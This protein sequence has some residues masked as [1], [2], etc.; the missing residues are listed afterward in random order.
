M[1][2]IETELNNWVKIFQFN[3]YFL[4]PFVF[5]GQSNSVWSLETSI[6]RTLVNQSKLGFGLMFGYE[7]EEKWMLHEFK[8][9][10]PL[11]SKVLPKQ[12]DNFEWLAIMQ[13]YGAPT[14]LLDFTESLFIATYFSVIESTT[15]SA[16][17]CVN[18]YQLRDSLHSIF[19]LNY[20][21]GVQLK[22]EINDIHIELA[23]K[24]I[25]SPFKINNES[26]QNSVIPLEPNIYTERLSK[27]QG[28]FLMPTNSK[29]SFSENLLSGLDRTSNEQFEQMEFDKL[30]EISN[31]RNHVN[32]IHVLKIILPR[33]IHMNIYSSLKEMN[34]TAE[35][36]FPGIDGLAKSL[37]LSHIQV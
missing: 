17:W 31:S 1:K 8:K 33:T 12:T 11:Y 36:L 14:R 37:V 18:R 26:W 6:E 2:L 3:K 7:T 20:E 15:D 29:V 4:A 25:A 21:H 16:I 23:N 10:Y 27:Q 35:N 13:H 32:D 9:K 5:R 22:D 28:L 30:I 19:N 24:F 34:I